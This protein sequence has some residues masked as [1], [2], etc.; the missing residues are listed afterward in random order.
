[1]VER[2]VRV[3]VTEVIVSGRSSVN[4]LVRVAA[5]IKEKAFIL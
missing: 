3:H 4:G 5:W 1:L 2:A